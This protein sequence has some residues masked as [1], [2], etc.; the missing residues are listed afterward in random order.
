M[1]PNTS[2]A[3]WSRWTLA[4]YSLVVLLSLALAVARLRQSTHMPGLAAI[5]L[6]LLAL[7][8]TLGLGVPPI[9]HAPL[10]VDVALV[11]LGVIINGAVLAAVTR[12]VERWWR[13]ASRPRRPGREHF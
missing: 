8:W 3:G 12:R 2:R 9:A 6:V 5:E 10:S 13:S 7:P 4:V 11:V 1:R